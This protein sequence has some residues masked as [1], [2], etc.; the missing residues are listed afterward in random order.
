MG[1]QEVLQCL[2]SEKKWMCVIEIAIATGTNIES[3]RRSLRQMH[4]YKEV[5]RKEM[6]EISQY[7]G[8]RVRYWKII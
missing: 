7:R 2:Q 3:V 5:M 8:I 4:K 6:K 1:Q